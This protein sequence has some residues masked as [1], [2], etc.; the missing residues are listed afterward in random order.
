M[1]NVVATLGLI[2]LSS[3]Q[4]EKEVLFKIAGSPDCI[5]KGKE[6]QMKAKITSTDPNEYLVLSGFG[7]AIKKIEGKDNYILMFPIVPNESRVTFSIRNKKTKKT[8]EVDS[9]DFT[10]CE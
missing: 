6:Y 2:I 10:F 1:R 5:V 3:F 4:T 9:I 8:R 7:V